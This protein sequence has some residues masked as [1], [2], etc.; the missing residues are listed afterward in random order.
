MSEEKSSFDAPSKEP[1]SSGS[2]YA[3]RVCV[4]GCRLPVLYGSAASRP[5]PE[6]GAC[7]SG[8]EVRS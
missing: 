3:V 7:V 4:S 2:V 1:S 8:S 6:C 5:L